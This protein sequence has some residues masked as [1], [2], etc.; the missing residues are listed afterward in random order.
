MNHSRP[1]SRPIFLLFFLLF[2]VPLFSLTIQS[3]SWEA[4]FPIDEAALNQASGLKL[5]QLYEPAAVRQAISNIQSYLQDGNHRYFVRIPF[6]ELIPVADSLMRLHFTLTEVTPSDGV[7][8]RFYGMRY[9]S[10]ARLNEMLLISDTKRFALADI[11]RI[12]SELLQLYHRR[13]FLF[14]KVQLDSLV[15]DEGLTAWI[16]VDEGKV[17]KAD[18]IHFQGNNHSRDAALLK[19]SGLNTSRTITPKELE[20]AR[21]KLLKA[22]YIREAVVEPIDFN[23]LLIKVREGRMTYLEGVLGYD[24]AKKQLSGKLRLEFLNLWG[25]DRSLALNWQKQQKQNLLEFSYHESGPYSFPLEGDL[26]FTRS[27]RD[28]L[29]I[30]SKLSVAANTRLSD[31][32]LGLE[33]VF[34]D[35]LIDQS[36]TKGASKHHINRSIAAIYGYD[37]AFPAQNPHKGRQARLAYRYIYTDNDKWVRAFELDNELFIPL[38]RQPVL[39]LGLHF[40]DL[41]DTDAKSWDQYHMG[42]Y[43]NL[44]GYKQQEFSSWRLGYLSWEFR[45]LLD[46]YSRLHLFFDHGAIAQKGQT[47]P[48]DKITYKSDIFAFGFGIKVRTRLGILGIDYALA[49]T[50]KGLSKPANGMIHAGLDTSF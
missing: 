19:L 38:G 4:N 49:N 1:R 40:R 7:K 25:S 41:S 23:S 35:N 27:S 43:E 22:P 12:S 42:G 11:E 31:H 9:F 32:K 30:Q 6:P 28:T 36:L 39:A 29:W 5:P 10:E 17:F 33:Y 20:E 47:E 26:L 3:L 18:Q 37:T 24:G 50:L 34:T 21:R 44:R 48:K 2:S 16:N 14:A 45:W 15:L 13:G 46:S 8:L